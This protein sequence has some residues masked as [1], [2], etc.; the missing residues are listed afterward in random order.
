MAWA[1]SK[2]VNIIIN[3]FTDPDNTVRE[4]KRPK[5]TSTNGIKAWKVFAGQFKKKLTIPTAI[6]VYNYSMNAIDTADQLRVA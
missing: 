6:D 1:D 4:R 3:A 5:K 2:V